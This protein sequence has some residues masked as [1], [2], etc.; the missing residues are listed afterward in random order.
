MGIISLFTFAFA[1]HFGTRPIAFF[2]I[3][4]AWFFFAMAPNII[5][6]LSLSDSELLHLFYIFRIGL[7][8]AWS[9]DLY[10]TIYQGNY[11]VWMDV[12]YLGLNVTLW[13]IWMQL[14]SRKQFAN[15][16][17]TAWVGLG[18]G[19]VILLVG[20]VNFTSLY[21]KA[22]TIE[23]E[24]IQALNDDISTAGIY[25]SDYDIL[26][27]YNLGF[28]N[29]RA[30][31]VVKNDS[32]LVV[33]EIPMSL[34]HTLAVTDSNLK[35]KRRGNLLT[36]MLDTP[37]E[38]GTTTLLEVSY[39]GNIQ[40][41]NN[42]YGKPRQEYFSTDAYLYLPYSAMWYPT[43]GTNVQIS[44]REDTSAVSPEIPIDR[45]R[46]EILTPRIP[47]I[48]NLVQKSDT[49]FY[50][51]HV[52]SVDLYGSDRFL[53]KSQ[54]QAVGYAATILSRKLGH[55]LEDFR[56]IYDKYSRFYPSISSKNLTLLMFER[57]IT[58]LPV[59]DQVIVAL[60]PSTM[61]IGFYSPYLKNVVAKQ[62]VDN[63]WFHLSGELKR[64]PY[65]EPITNL[66]SAQGNKR[67]SMVQL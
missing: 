12:F 50:G 19:I 40:F 51:E 24:H 65:H 56:A 16:V 47:I 64:G 20:A 10:G 48:C 38:P 35:T 4:G 15:F 58:T 23:S 17:K 66:R 62:I 11:F 63:F 7:D 60:R 42:S 21:T 3:L 30:A 37:L 31:M 59:Q 5:R 55:N 13:F 53:R 67:F 34:Y 22:N 26:F 28:L 57:A 61:N 41:W 45:F 36:F 46:L 14:F 6:A 2:T 52:L 54:E 1:R 29:I 18:I 44:H 32:E 27:Q 33:A 8:P 43:I 25:I 9:N 49:V 39:E